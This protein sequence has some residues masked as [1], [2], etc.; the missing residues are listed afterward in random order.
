MYHGDHCHEQIVT[1]NE[2]GAASVSGII[3]VF[4]N[5]ILLGIVCG[6]AARIDGHRNRFKAC[7]VNV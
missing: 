2:L 5:C 4:L 1:N 3:W 6:V 7:I